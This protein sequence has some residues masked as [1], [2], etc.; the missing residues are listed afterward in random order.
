MFHS[1]TLLIYMN[2]KQLF[3][4]MSIAVFSKQNHFHGKVFRLDGKFQLLKY[5]IQLSLIGYYN[6]PICSGCTDCIAVNSMYLINVIIF[7]DIL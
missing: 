1:P 4:Y 2:L 5:L 7:S 3:F 6:G